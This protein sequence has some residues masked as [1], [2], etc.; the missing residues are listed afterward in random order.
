LLYSNFTKNEIPAKSLKK[1]SSRRHCHIVFDSSG[2]RAYGEDK[3][4]V[5]KH[6]SSERRTWRKLHIGMD[7]DS[8]KIMIS[9]LA[10]NG[11]RSDDSEIREKAKE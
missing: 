5:R 6:E 11:V 1:L 7:P 10:T 4:K 9:E 8:K 3:W 2:L